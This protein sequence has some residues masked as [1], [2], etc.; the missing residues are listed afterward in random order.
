LY[1]TNFGGGLLHPSS[2]LVTRQAEMSAGLIRGIL[3]IR[4]DFSANFTL[5]MKPIPD[6]D[7]DQPRIGKM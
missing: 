5:K 4:Y 6:L 3:R 7:R 1:N 2:A